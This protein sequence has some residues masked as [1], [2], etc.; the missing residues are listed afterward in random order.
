MASTKKARSP[1]VKE[2]DA[3]GAGEIQAQGSRLDAA[4]EDTD[5]HRHLK[6]SDFVWDFDMVQFWVSRELMQ[7]WRRC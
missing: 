7:G 5:L 2:D 6:S 4:E 3:I 1:A